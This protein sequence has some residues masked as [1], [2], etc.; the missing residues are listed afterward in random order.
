MGSEMCIRDSLQLLQLLTG[1]IAVAYKLIELDE[2]SDG[3]VGQLFLLLF[4]VILVLSGSSLII[5]VLAEGWSNATQMLRR[6]RDTKQRLRTLDR[7]VEQATEQG[8]LHTP[9]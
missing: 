8:W 2:R 7:F 4:M 6:R 1:K 3:V 5:S 9:D